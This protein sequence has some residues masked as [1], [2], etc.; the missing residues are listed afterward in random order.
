MVLISPKTWRFVVFY[1]L[2][3][4]MAA[5]VTAFLWSRMR[6]RYK[7]P[8]WLPLFVGVQV[9]DLAQGALFTAL[10]S[11]HHNNQWLRHIAQPIVYVG[12]LLV[13]FRMGADRSGRRILYSL[14]L[15][16]GLAA[17]VAGALLNGFAWRNVLFTTTMSIVYIGLTTLELRHMVEAEGDTPLTALPEFW[18]STAL[19]IYGSGTLVFNASSNYF[20]RTLS[21]GLLPIPWVVAATIHAIH[22]LLLAKVF[23]CPKPSSS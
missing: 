19:L 3:P 23:L 16:I 21:P 7:R 14:S 9:F 4:W 17:A 2:N 6:W 18:L 5:P 15:G 11:M 10:A 22:H 12:L 1:I 20:L 13:L 8:A